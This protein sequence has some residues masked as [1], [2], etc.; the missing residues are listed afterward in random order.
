MV[1]PQNDTTI[2]HPYIYYY[3]SFKLKQLLP[4]VHKCAKIFKKLEFP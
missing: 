1:T 2:Y 3:I 4:S